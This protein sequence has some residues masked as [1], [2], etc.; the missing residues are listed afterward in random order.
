MHKN[1]RILAIEAIAASMLLASLSHNPSLAETYDPGVVHDVD[2]LENGNLLVSEGGIPG[3]TDSGVFEIDRDGNI[4][5]SYTTGL[6]W[7]HNADIQ[8]DSSIVISDTGNDRVII[9]E[10][11]G[12][13]IWDTDD[14]ILD[15]GSELD[16]PNDAN[17]LDN[18]NVRDRHS[19]APFSHSMPPA[20]IS[21]IASDPQCRPVCGRFPPQ[22]CTALPPPSRP[23]LAAQSD[24]A[25]LA[26]NGTHRAGS[27]P[28]RCQDTATTRAIPNAPCVGRNHRRR[29]DPTG[30]LPE[31][32]P[33]KGKAR[34]RAPAPP[35]AREYGASALAP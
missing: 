26:P 3:E 25:Y 15:D 13:V 18:G 33:A 20:W 34:E 8:P 4:V 6:A 32:A 19:K 16:Y 30:T 9:V 14:I 22:V 11:D 27:A 17:L 2:L 5:W 21:S 7:T 31:V 29:P 24:L 28:D 10:R 23:P 12:T 1:F 35:C